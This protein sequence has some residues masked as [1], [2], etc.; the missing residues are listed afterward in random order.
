MKFLT[1]LF[2]EDGTYAG[3]QGNER[4][5]ADDWQPPTYLHPGDTR[6]RRYL[7]VHLG[8]AE[9]PGN[10]RCV[11]TDLA[12]ALE[13]HPESTPAAP[14]FGIKSIDRMPQIL[15]APVALADFPAW[16]RANGPDR[17]AMPLRAWLTL[18]MPELAATYGLDRGIDIEA[19]IAVERRRVVRPEHSMLPEL[20]LWLQRR[21]AAKRETI[22]ERQ[23]Q[24][25]R[26][27]VEA[28]LAG[29]DIQ[30]STMKGV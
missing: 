27:R 18:H 24:A 19:M 16:M 6:V 17:M 28:L 20:E 2:F 30:P 11:S 7:A 23:R 3:T 14:K 15:D 26:R 4:P 12:E 21:E 5:L 9:M 29:E 10:G 22:L 8:A 25:E 13:P 1:V